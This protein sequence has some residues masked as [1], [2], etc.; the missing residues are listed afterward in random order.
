MKNRSYYAF[1]DDTQGAFARCSTES[2]TAPLAVNCAGEMQSAFPF[3]TDNAEGRLDYYLMYIKSGELEVS[4]PDGDRTLGAGTAV[5]FPPR[6]RYRYRFAGGG[7][8]SYLWCHFT[9]SDVSRLLTELGLAPLPF[10]RQIGREGAILSE[11]ERIF[12]VFSEGGVFRDPILA[13]TLEGLLL[14]VAR[15]SAEP[16]SPAPLSRS[17][18]YINE[19]YTRDI[20]IPDLARME[21]LSNSRYHVLFCEAFGMPPSR[22]VTKLRVQSA[23]ELLLTTDLPVKQV[24]LSVGYDD[25]H[26]FSKIFK[27]YA[28]VSPT[29]YRSK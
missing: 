21:N 9:G 11:F 24:G 4:F 3:S 18:G 23:C 8:I 5:I 14:T 2:L 10:H 7:Q 13:H 20:R 22:Y 27:A 1:D 16:A 6:R 28:G 17:V 25:P 15:A 19:N 26:F 12:S 29:K